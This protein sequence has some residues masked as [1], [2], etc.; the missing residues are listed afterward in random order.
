MGLISYRL[1]RKFAQKHH[2]FSPWSVGVVNE[3]FLT[4]ALRHT[5]MVLL[6]VISILAGIL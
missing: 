6:L 2:F 1:T 3:V 4:F 5:F